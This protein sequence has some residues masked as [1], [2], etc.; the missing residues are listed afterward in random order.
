MHIPTNSWLP[1]HIAKK[2]TKQMN[3]SDDA[4]VF[5]P[6]TTALKLFHSAAAV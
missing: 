3:N 1:F 2:K 5:L 4:P 6:H